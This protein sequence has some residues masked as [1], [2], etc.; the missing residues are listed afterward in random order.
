MAGW[1]LF[2]LVMSPHQGM[3]DRGSAISGAHGYSSST[4]GGIRL[5]RILSIILVVWLRR[6]PTTPEFNPQPGNSKVSGSSKQPS[7]LAWQSHS[8]AQ[9]NFV[10]SCMTTLGL[11]ITLR[12][13]VHD[14]LLC[15]ILISQHQFPQLCLLLNT[16][17]FYL[18]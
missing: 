11:D 13:A 8:V 1:F 17:N 18:G 5:L 15:G 7:V 2:L 3:A 6:G 14:N 16:P 12:F 10:A 4:A 9:H